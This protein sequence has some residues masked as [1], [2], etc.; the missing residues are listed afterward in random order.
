MTGKRLRPGDM[1]VL[2][3]QHLQYIF[4]SL[5]K[6]GYQVIGP[7][8]REGA[9]VYEELSSP[10][11]LPV[12]WTD[13]QD[14]GT[15]RLKKRSDGA[16]FGYNVG[17]HSWKRFLHPPSVQLWRASRNSKGFQ[18]AAQKK[19]SAKYAFVGVRA[20]EL[21][22]IAIQDRV[23]TGG[24]YIDPGY[25]ARR[26]NAFIVAVNCGQAGGACFCASM[27]TGPRAASGYDL[28][29]TEVLE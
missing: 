12:G 17:P 27:N 24:P 14:G 1:A 10:T 26:E 8:V 13:D 20:C 4:D 19:E 5:V 15:Y 22:A 3:P 7:T 21:H 9:I 6:R 25:Q 18:V 28:A 11:N 23:F 29:L 2:E 16:L